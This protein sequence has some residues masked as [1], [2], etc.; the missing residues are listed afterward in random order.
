MTLLSRW[1]SIP[2]LLYRDLV[3]SPETLVP[4]GSVIPVQIVSN[5]E[6]LPVVHLPDQSHEWNGK[7]SERNYRVLGFFQP[8]NFFYV[9]TLDMFFFFFNRHGF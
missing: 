6:W 2:S 8:K 7:L 1:E 9:A 5:Q 3:D 4:C